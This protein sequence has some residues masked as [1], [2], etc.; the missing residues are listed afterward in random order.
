MVRLLNE[1]EKCHHIGPEIYISKHL[2]C[3]PV[4]QKMFLTDVNNLFNCFKDICNPF[5]EDQ[6]ID[7]KTGKKFSHV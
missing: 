4:F 5:E 1:Y 7:L 6:L 3:Y 2:E